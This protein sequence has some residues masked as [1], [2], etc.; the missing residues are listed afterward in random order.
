MQFKDIPGQLEVKN[1]LITTVKT[2][3]IPHAQLFMGPQGCCSLN[4][5]IAYAQY[6]SCQNK[7]ENDSCGECSSCRKY[8][9]LAHPDLHFSFPYVTTSSKKETCDVFMPEWRIAL[10]KEACLTYAAWLNYLDAENKQLNI[11]I[12]ECHNILQKLSLKPFESEFKVLIMW[13][14]EYLG[15]E[16]NALLKLIEEPPHKTILLFVTEN[17]DAILSTILSRTQLIKIPK[18]EDEVIRSFLVENIEIS[19]ENAQKATFLAEGDL[20][21]AISTA[22]EL[23]NDYEE[24]F[25]NWMR[26]CYKAN[27]LTLMA[28]V[29]ETAKMRRESQKSFLRYGLGLLRECLLWNSHTK[30]LVKVNSQELEFVERFS[31]FVPFGIVSPILEEMEKAIY[32]IERNANAKIV[33]LDLSLRIVILLKQQSVT[34]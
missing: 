11:Y 15:K 6:I 13:L 8:Q 2:G 34:A 30:E 23:Q 7:Q 18:L 26:L 32:H 12:H 29:E 20:A 24:V 25:M 14:P 31:Q 9:K 33:F 27:G 22:Q 1:R 16:G 28:W 19:N 21:T 3:R 5:A 10:D 4:L 17:R